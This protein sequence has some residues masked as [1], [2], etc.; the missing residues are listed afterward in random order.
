MVTV[1]PEEPS[2]SNSGFAATQ[3]GHHGTPNIMNLH[4]PSA[5]PSIPGSIPERLATTFAT[6]TR[7]I[8]K[9][10]TM[11]QYDFISILSRLGVEFFLV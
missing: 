8:M 4:D 6:K 7:T 11:T 3:C 9:P 1:G 2:F 5:N 10:A